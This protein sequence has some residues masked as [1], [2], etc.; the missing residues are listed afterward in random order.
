MTL[1]PY[2]TEIISE[3][4]DSMRQG[5]KSILTVAPTGSGK[6]AMF[7][8]IAK[9]AESKNSRVMILVHR[10]EILE[11]TLSALFRLGI[12]SGQ[13]MSGR[14]A[15]QDTI[16]TAM[17][18]S[19]VRRLDTMRRPDLII[20]DE[21]HHALE[22]NSWGTILRYWSDVPRL[23]FTATPERAD[24]RGLV[25]TFSNMIL[26][27]SISDLVADG[28]LAP[29]VLYRPPV[30]ITA[31][32]H[33]KRGDFDTAEQGKVM[34]GRKIVGDVIEHYREHLNGLPVVVFCVSIEHSRLMAEQFSR[35]GFVAR[36][37]WGNMPK[38]DRE[39]AIKGLA[40][41]SVQVVTSCDVISEGVDIPV[42]AGAILLRRTASLALYLQ[43]AGRALRMY[44]G[45][46]R[47]VILDHAGNYALHGHVLADR[48]WTLDAGTRAERKERPPMTVTCPRCYGVWPGQ[49]RTCPACGFNFATAPARDD[50]EIKMVAGKL[51]E[52]GLE[53]PEAE[54]MAGVYA[55]A[56]AAQGKERQ[57]ILLGAAYNAVDKRTVDQ[58]A[59][60]AGYNPNWSSWAWG[61]V[62]KKKQG[63]RA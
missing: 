17:V 18:G 2:Q 35:A 6:T 53:G 19:L 8:S 4:R 23:G 14:Q 30:E 31:Q 42:M 52:A 27:P 41:G 5:N 47:A 22:D 25:E 59:Q 1:R 56:M 13:V 55:R 36:V 51:V 40:D 39:A 43:Q 37:V 54:R 57:K 15:T 61:Y 10:R 50:R 3:I 49:P 21:C 20:V 9:G 11:Q 33:V 45:K 44:P 28:F 58:L 24:G 63:G 12:T 29:P 46:T 62:Q 48:N 34:S 16:Q 60:L 7:A 38:A 26:G 32:Y